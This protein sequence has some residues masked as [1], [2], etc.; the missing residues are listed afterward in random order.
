MRCV[1]SEISRFS[2]GY[3][4]DCEGIDRWYSKGEFLEE[5]KCDLEAI[6]CAEVCIVVVK[7]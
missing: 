5:I 4:R 7:E 3:V 2:P 1:V 6:M